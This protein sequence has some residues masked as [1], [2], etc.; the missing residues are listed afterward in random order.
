LE[1]AVIELLRVV[2][3]PAVVLVVAWLVGSRIQSSSQLELVINQLRRDV[4]LLQDTVSRL[5]NDRATVAGL[6][7]QRDRVNHL[8]EKLRELEARLGPP[9]AV[10]APPARRV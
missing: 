9:S 7:M 5:E 4:A 3:W 8:E 6:M 1:G 10:K 2:I